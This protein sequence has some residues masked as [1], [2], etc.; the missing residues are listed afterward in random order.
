MIFI[1]VVPNR[2][3]TVRSAAVFYLSI[4]AMPLAIAG[5]FAMVGFWPIL[6]VAG[7]EVLALG[8]ALWWTLRKTKTRELIEIDEHNVLVRKKRPDRNEEHEFS[9]H[10]IQVRLVQPA[11]ALWPSRLLLRSGGRTIEVGSFLTNSERDGLQR[12]LTELIGA[13]R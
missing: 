13:G 3:L 9:R 8:A 11:S 2:S 4:I 6:T 1:E 10:W 5:L 12:R 7:V